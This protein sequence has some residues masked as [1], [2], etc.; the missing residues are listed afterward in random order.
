MKSTQL[1]T[2]CIILAIAISTELP[3]RAEKGGKKGGKNDGPSSNLPSFS[4][5][6]EVLEVP[7]MRLLKD[8]NEDGLALITVY[9]DK[10]GLTLSEQVINGV[11]YNRGP[12]IVD[13][14]G[15][16]S[17]GSTSYPTVYLDLMLTEEDDANWSLFNAEHI[18]RSGWVAGLGFSAPDATATEP[19][20]LIPN[21][22]NGLYD[23]VSFPSLPS[24]GSV[25][26]RELTES[27]DVLVQVGI[28]LFLLHN[29]SSV[30]FVGSGV[31]GYDMNSTG[32][33][34]AT[35]GN[36][37]ENLIYNSDS[38]VVELE[39]PEGTSNPDVSFEAALSDTGF[40]AGVHYQ[41]RRYR[42][43]YIWD[44]V[45]VVFDLSLAD[46]LGFA[47]VTE[48]PLPAG[49]SVLRGE[50][51]ASEVIIDGLPITG[52]SSDQNQ[53]YIFIPGFDTANVVQ[54][55]MDSEQQQNWSSLGIGPSSTDNSNRAEAMTS[56]RD[57]SGDVDSNGAPT[58]FGEWNRL[59]VEDGSNAGEFDGYQGLYLIRP[60]D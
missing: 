7:G 13:T 1:L 56:P 60:I 52:F 59:T 34:I 9:G 42:G 35:E 43:S 28:D 19:Y 46:S 41:G 17:N 44:P 20:L 57:A 22:E 6:V 3:L 54:D 12:A 53:L 33:I 21:L 15:V 47:P 18:N 45:P 50:A 31:Y 5:E 2:S 32:T 55:L 14:S 11:T 51:F 37:P 29:D 48:L 8:V 23:L 30:T 10:L 24:T 39:S 16:E 38:N 36:P 25:K 40:A 49:V 27:G 58:F 26:I 4:Y